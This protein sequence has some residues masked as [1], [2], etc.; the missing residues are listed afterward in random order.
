MKGVNAPPLTFS[1]LRLPTNERLVPYGADP[2][3]WPSDG[4]GR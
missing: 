4:T 2:A 1:D 3:A